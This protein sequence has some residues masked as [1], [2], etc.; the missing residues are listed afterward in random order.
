MWP[1]DPNKELKLTCST[2]RNINYELS[3]GITISKA[4]HLRIQVSRA[5]EIT[6]RRKCI[7]TRE[8]FRTFGELNMYLKYNFDLGA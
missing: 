8:H 6:E 2:K 7:Q 3:E 5:W 1:T 4:F